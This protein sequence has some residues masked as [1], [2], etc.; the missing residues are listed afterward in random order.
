M[1]NFFQTQAQTKNRE[2]LHCPKNPN[3]IGNNLHRILRGS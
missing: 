3:E 1:L 2:Y